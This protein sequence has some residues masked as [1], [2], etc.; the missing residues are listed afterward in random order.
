M[1]TVIAYF[2]SAIAFAIIDFGWLSLTANRLYRPVIGEL[3]A[4][5]VALL[6]GALFYVI[7]WLGVTL[8][9]TVPALKEGSVGKAAGT[10]ALVALVAYATYDLTNQATLKAWAWRITL[11]DLAWGVFATTLATVIGFYAARLLTKA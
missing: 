4:P 11:A 1:Q 8:L 7:Y 3:M 5:K 2:V 10:A 9:A 6:P